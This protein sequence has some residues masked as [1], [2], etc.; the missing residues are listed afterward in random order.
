MY[1]TVHVINSIQDSEAYAS[2]FVE[3]IEGYFENFEGM[4]P[5]YW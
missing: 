3:N 1:I 4:F 2:E 5:D